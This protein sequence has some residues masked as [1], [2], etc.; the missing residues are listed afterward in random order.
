MQEM[1]DLFSFRAASLEEVADITRRRFVLDADG[2]LHS[3]A[4]ADPAPER[5]NKLL[6]HTVDEEFE[7]VLYEGNLDGC[8]GELA[9]LDGGGAWT[10]RTPALFCVENVLLRQLY[11]RFYYETLSNGDL[12]LHIPHVLPETGQE[13]LIRYTDDH[14]RSGCVG[15]EAAVLDPYKEELEYI[16]L[17]PVLP[18]PEGTTL[19]TAVYAVSMLRRSRLAAQSAPEE[20]SYPLPGPAHAEDE[21]LQPEDEALD[22]ETETDPDLDTLFDALFEPLEEDRPG[23]R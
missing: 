4:P 11:D 1:K 8:Q 7:R 16:P 5:M 23:G 9:D 12:V 6:L 15:M 14:D 20:D 2:I 22:M 17:P 18:E 13:L 10:D 21:Y 3:R 19:Y